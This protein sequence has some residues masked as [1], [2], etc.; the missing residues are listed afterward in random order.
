M[1][2]NLKN[3]MLCLIVAS[4]NIY[5]EG[6]CTLASPVNSVIDLRDGGIGFAY[7]AIPSLVNS[8]VALGGEC[9]VQLRATNL[10][11]PRSKILQDF[12]N[13]FELRSFNQTV[14][15]FDIYLRGTGQM[16]FMSIDFESYESYEASS[17]LDLYITPGAIPKNSSKASTYFI[18]GH[19]YSWGPGD[20]AENYTFNTGWL[21]AHTENTPEVSVNWQTNNNYAPYFGMKLDLNIGNST[22]FPISV[23]PPA[24]QGILLPWRQQTFYP[25]SKTIGSLSETSLVPQSSFLLH[26]VS[27]CSRSNGVTTTVGSCH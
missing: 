3:A 12:V 7:G 18:T 5:A 25:T 27:S 6:G 17:R 14:R 24:G 21:P 11:A 4:S 20:V 22:V 9:Q 16:K 23:Y 2:I 8:D 1:L 13:P 15:I 26:G 19:W 10:P